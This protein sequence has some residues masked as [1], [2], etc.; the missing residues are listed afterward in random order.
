LNLKDFRLIQ[1]RYYSS[2][3]LNRL[4]RIVRRRGLPEK[5]INNRCVSC[6]FCVRRNA[7]L[8]IAYCFRVLCPYLGKGYINKRRRESDLIS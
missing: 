4:F 6:D 7:I 1:A 3:M 2:T 8:G 5:F